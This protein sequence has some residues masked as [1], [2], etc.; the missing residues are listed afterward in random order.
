MAY[1]VGAG[2]A[3]G[4]FLLAL[5]LLSLGLPGLDGLAQSVQPL[6]HARPVVLLVEQLALP[7]AALLLD[8][9]PG[10]RGAAGHPSLVR[11]SRVCQ[12]LGVRVGHGA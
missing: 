12:G 10:L 7:V 8:L 11:V 1:L 9:V 5:V 6:L 4:Q 3:V 2:V